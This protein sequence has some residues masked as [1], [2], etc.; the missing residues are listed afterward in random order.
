MIQNKW[1]MRDVLND[2]ENVKHVEN[3]IRFYFD[4]SDSKTFADFFNKYDQ[5]YDSMMSLHRDRQH[6]KHLHSKT[7][8][9]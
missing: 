7:V 4:T 8:K 5:Y 6:R 9:G 1:N 3:L 2:I